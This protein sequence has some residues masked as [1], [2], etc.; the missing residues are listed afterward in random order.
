M[1]VELPIEAH[2]AH[3]CSLGCM[4]LLVLLVLLL[5]STKHTLQQRQQY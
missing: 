5:L 2:S 1:F 4:F 3:C